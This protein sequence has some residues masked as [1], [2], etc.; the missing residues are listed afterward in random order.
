MRKIFLV[1]YDSACYF[2]A[3]NNQQ[4]HEGRIVTWLNSGTEVSISVFSLN[5]QYDEGMLVA[6][7][8]CCHCDLFG[9]ALGRDGNFYVGSEFCMLF[10]YLGGIYAKKR[11][12]KVLYTRDFI[13]PE[14]T[15]PIL[16]SVDRQS[17]LS[18]LTLLQAYS[19]D[20]QK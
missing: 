8:T 12:S 10:E 4:A 1:T 19:L 17:I 16:G 20:K 2:E 11:R 18:K 15:Y 7:G 5:E 9:S 3:V 14:R 13:H 6:I